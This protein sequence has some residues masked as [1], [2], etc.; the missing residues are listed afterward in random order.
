[1]GSSVEKMVRS[2]VGEGSS[3]EE[4]RLCKGKDLCGNVDSCNSVTFE[5]DI[6]VAK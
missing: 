3:I 1:M 6:F 2:K 4:R 5:E